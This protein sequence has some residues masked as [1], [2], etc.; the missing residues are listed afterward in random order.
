[1]RVTMI[2]SAHVGLVFGARFADLGHDVVCVDKGPG[3]IEGLMNRTQLVD[4]K[5][6]YR[7]QEARGEGFD[8]VG[9][10]KP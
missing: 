8:Y 7:S 9:I 5:N 1:M 6:L 3:K 10:G 4:L 2:G